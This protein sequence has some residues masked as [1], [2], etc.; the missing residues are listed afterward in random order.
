MTGTACSRRVVMIKSRRGPATGVMA[1]L[2]DI[3]GLIMRRRFTGSVLAIVAT[4]AVTANTAVIE[5]GGIPGRGI[6]AITTGIGR[7]DVARRLGMTVGA[8][9]SS[10]TVIKLHRNPVAGV[11]T[12]ITLCRGLYM[13]A[14]F[15]VTT[16][17]GLGY[18][19][20]VETRGGPIGRVVATIT[21]FR[22][23][24]MPTRFR[25]TTAAW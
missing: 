23:C 4:E 14:R 21:R 25:V 19:A 7:S 15:V 17:A 5:A 9:F 2:T 13:A 18:A 8:R 24:N 3:V 12:G 1:I 20:V 10:S 16:T 11:M 6:V 22:S